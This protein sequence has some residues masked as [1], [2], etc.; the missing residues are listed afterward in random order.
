MTT[1]S[2]RQLWVDRIKRPERGDGPD[3]LQRSHW[4]NGPHRVER[5]DG[6]DRPHRCQ[7][8]DWCNRRDRQVYDVP[9]YSSY[10]LICLKKSFLMNF[11]DTT[12]ALSC[13]QLWAHWV[14]RPDRFQRLEWSDRCAE[15]LLCLH[16]LPGSHL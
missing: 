8:P 14:D 11:A 13:R 7:W 9:L 2:C 4:I 1:F 10:A 3:R 12:T 16:H 6:I 15:C 5:S